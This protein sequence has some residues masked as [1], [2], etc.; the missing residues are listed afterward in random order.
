[1]LEPSGVIQRELERIQI[2]LEADQPQTPCRPR[3]LTRDHGPRS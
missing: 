2:V 1:M 3:T